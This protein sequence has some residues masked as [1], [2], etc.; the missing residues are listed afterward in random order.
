MDRLIYEMYAWRLIPE[1]IRMDNG[2]VDDW[3]MYVIRGCCCGRFNRSAL[4]QVSDNYRR[5]DRVR[6]E[7]WFGGE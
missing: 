1:W 6:V 7:D 4:I 3:G 2:D 5:E